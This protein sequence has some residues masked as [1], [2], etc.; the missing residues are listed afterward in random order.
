MKGLVH[1]YTGCGKGKTTC[2]LGLALRA[3]GWGRRV[4]MVQFIKGWGDTGESRF[5]ALCPDFDL[6]QTAENKTLSITK[7]YVEQAGEACREAFRKAEEI[8][9]GGSYDLV[10]LDEINGA[11]DYGLVPEEAVL[12]LIKNKPGPLELVLTGRNAREKI[13]AAADYV[14]EMKLIKHPYDR[15]IKARKGTDF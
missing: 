4:C 10:I 2:S 6:V 3:L 15:G 5:A 13:M 8:I 11:V 9:R 14:T 12:E 1:V 7:D